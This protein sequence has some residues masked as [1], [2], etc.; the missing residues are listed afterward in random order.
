MMV[1]E[2]RMAVLFSQV[3]VNRSGFAER[4]SL[5]FGAGQFEIRQDPERC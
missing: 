4:A 3:S 5:K 2:G 1:C